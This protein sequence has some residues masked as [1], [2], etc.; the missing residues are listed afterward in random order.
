MVLDIEGT[1]SSLSYVRDNLFSYSRARLAEWV[2]RD[3]PPA[4]AVIHGVRQLTGQP[5]AGLDEVTEILRRWVDDDVKAAPLKELQGLIWEAGFAAGELAA[6][7]YDDVPAALR[8]WAEAGL[9]SYVYSSGSVRAQRAWLRATQHGNLL[10][11][12][13]GHF[14]TVNAGPKKEPRSYAAIAAAVNLPSDRLIFYSDSRAEL[15]A[16]LAAGWRAVGVRR[17]DNVDV[18]LGSHR[19]IADFGGK[20]L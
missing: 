13:A 18:D 7:V 8:M 19:S 20:D 3:D 11:L 4:R 5:S 2:Q 16:A 17:P 1:V 14:D 9:R 10:P 15:D 6:H 12:I